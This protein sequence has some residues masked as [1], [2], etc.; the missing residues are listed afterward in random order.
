MSAHRNLND[1]RQL[2]SSTNK[3]VAFQSNV[4]AC[5]VLLKTSV[6]RSCN[7]ENLS[8]RFVTS[9]RLQIVTDS[10]D[11]PSF[12][13]F[14]LS[15]FSFHHLSFSLHWSSISH[16]FLLNLTLPSDYTRLQFRG[17]HHAWQHHTP[18]LSTPQPNILHTLPGPSPSA[19]MTAVCILVRLC[20]CDV[21]ICRVPLVGGLCL[22]LM[23]GVMSRPAQD[24]L[25]NSEKDKGWPVA[26]E[27]W[28]ER[29]G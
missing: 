29:G 17:V 23:T 24:K 15:Y 6:I 22:R 19:A 18:H 3:F 13:S 2:D 9:L 10:V 8:W 20:V 27:R 4:P 25:M 12:Q 11:F 1:L 28:G 5:L 7:T 14:R 26:G 21:C 16:H